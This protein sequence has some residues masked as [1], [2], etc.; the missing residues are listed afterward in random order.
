[1]CFEV[2]LSLLLP[3]FHP[4]APL[5]ISY[6]CAPLL[7]LLT[8]VLRQ[9]GHLLHFFATFVAG[10][11]VGFTSVWQIALVTLAVAP[12]LVLCGGLKAVALTGLTTKSLEA[13]AVAGRIVEEVRASS[14]TAPETALG[15]QVHGDVCGRREGWLRGEVVLY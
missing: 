14:D 7:I 2:A 12:L 15:T 4:C 13:Y 5:L 11:A 6:L 1:M 10:F 8:P 3:F 9:V